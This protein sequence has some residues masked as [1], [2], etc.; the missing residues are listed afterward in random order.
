MNVTLTHNGCVYISG[1]HLD[2]FNYAQMLM[3]T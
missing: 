3:Q 2:P 1:L